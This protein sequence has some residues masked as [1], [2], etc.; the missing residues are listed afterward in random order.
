[1]VAFSGSFCFTSHLPF[2]TPKIMLAWIITVFL[3]AGYPYSPLSSAAIKATHS[4]TRAGRGVRP[5]YFLFFSLS[6]RKFGREKD[7]R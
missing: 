1:M 4:K 3:V 2:N 6:A 5:P 7:A